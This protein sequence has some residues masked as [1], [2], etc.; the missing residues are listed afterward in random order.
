[1]LDGGSILVDRMHDEIALR[2][3]IDDPRSIRGMDNDAQPVATTCVLDDAIRTGPRAPGQGL[4]EQHH[5]DRTREHARKPRYRHDI[6]RFTCG[7]GT[8]PE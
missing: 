1:V 7:C 8:S 2:G 3:N 4:T 5:D 6:L